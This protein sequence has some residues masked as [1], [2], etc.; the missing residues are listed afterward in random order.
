MAPIRTSLQERDADLSVLS[1]T[2]AETAGLFMDDQEPDWAVLDVQP[3][4][5]DIGDPDPIEPKPRADPSERSDYTEYTPPPK[6][7]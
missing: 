7:A 3:D 2:V 5:I 1:A 6:A 4:E